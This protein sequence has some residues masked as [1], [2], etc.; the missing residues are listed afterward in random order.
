[1]RIKQIKYSIFDTE[2][3]LITN[4]LELSAPVTL[5]NKKDLNR[6]QCKQS[7]K[8]HQVSLEDYANKPVQ[9]DLTFKF[10]CNEAVRPVNL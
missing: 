8:S 10:I 1:M 3:R 5:D 7:G 6:A 2:T 4:K 9:E